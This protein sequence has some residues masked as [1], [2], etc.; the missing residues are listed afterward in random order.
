MVHI[1]TDTY[2]NTLFKQS[3]AIKSLNQFCHRILSLK[4]SNYPAV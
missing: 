4:C 2:T 1:Q 3:N